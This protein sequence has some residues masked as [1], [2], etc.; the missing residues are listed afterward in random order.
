MSRKVE[1]GAPVVYNAEGERIP[2][3]E[4]SQY[5]DLVR[6]VA[7]AGKG[8]YSQYAYINKIKLLQKNTE[9][10]DVAEAGAF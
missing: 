10:E 5:G 9:A 3:N 4:L 6:V 8:D 7:T 2:N 1:F